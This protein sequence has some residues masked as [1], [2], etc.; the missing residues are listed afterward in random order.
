MTMLLIGR[1]QPV[2]LQNQLKTVCHCLPNLLQSRS[3][4]WEKCQT[5][6]WHSYVVDGWKVAYDFQ[7]RELSH[8]ILFL[9]PP[10]SENVWSACY[11][12]ISL[13]CS[14]VFLTFLV[15]FEGMGNIFFCVKDWSD[16]TLKVAYFYDEHFREKV[17]ERK[18]QSCIHFH[19]TELFAEKGK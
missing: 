12:Q 16:V 7:F 14:F 3:S 18:S 4:F 1:K 11:C 2:H 10:F 9:T 8:Q 5:M 17:L 15:A 6:K 19:G 13:L